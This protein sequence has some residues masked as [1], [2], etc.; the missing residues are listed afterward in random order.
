LDVEFAQPVDREP[1]AYDRVV[2]AAVE[3]QRVDVRE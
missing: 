1:V 3:V 2:V